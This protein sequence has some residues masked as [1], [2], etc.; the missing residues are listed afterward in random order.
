[1]SPVIKQMPGA[2]VLHTGQHYS[3]MLS[4]A[5]LEGFGIRVTKVLCPDHNTS[6]EALFGPLAYATEEW[7]RG[8]GRMGIMVVHGDTLSASAAAVGAKRA[9]WMVA[10]IEAGLRSGDLSMPEEVARIHMDAMADLLFAPT[11]IQEENLLGRK[12]VYVVGNTIQDVLEPYGLSKHNTHTGV[13]TLHRREN[14]I[15]ARDLLYR[16]HE[17][18]SLFGLDSVVFPMHPS[19]GHLAGYL[20]QDQVITPVA[21]IA[22]DEMIERIQSAYLVM[23]DSGGMQEE[24]AILGTPCITLRNTTERPE[25]VNTG[26]NMLMHPTLEGWHLWEERVIAFVEKAKGLKPYRYTEYSPA[27]MIVEV[28]ERAR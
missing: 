15:Y 23:T 12:G 14:H 7:C 18:G 21:P 6:V 11:P 26:W 19:V 5:F 24:C 28:L 2:V 8:A 10:H 27:R 3:P 17:I 4:E 13:L 20:S 22:Y 1:M 25:T 9:G 16:V